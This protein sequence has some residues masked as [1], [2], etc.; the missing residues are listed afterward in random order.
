[1]STPAY[2]LPY[3][4]AAARG[5]VRSMLF[6]DQRAQEIRFDAIVRNCALGGRRVLDVGCGRADLL[7]YL[8]AC[9][10]WPSHYTG[11]EAQATL[12][13]EARDRRYANCSIREGDFVR[14]PSL[15]DAG[16]DAVV[17]S[18]SLNLLEAAEF[19]RV[20]R[21]AWAATRESLVFNFLCS[22]RL[23]G[24]PWLVWRPLGPVA[25]FARSLSASVRVDAGYEAGDCTIA[26][27]R[28]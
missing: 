6:P 13:A 7:G 2:L 21:A 8:R 14:E 11:V 24:A 10:S 18:G 1:M 19:Y 23:A 15:L 9:G 20:L 16:A 26:L 12:A 5:G 17:L 28:S 22:P 4:R 27:T 25:R 3:E